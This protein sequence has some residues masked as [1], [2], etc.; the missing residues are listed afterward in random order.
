MPTMLSAIIAGPAAEG[1]EL[2]SLVMSFNFRC[3]RVLDILLPCSAR[4]R[5]CENAR[6][7]AMAAWTWS[8]IVAMASRTLADRR[9]VLVMALA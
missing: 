1:R 6:P 3:C 7:L 9:A 5:D 2:R 4:E 8:K